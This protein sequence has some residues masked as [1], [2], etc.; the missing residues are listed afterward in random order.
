MFRFSS[1]VVGLLV[2]F[3]VV[4]ASDA[5]FGQSTGSASSTEPSTYGWMGMHL[6]A[7]TPRGAVVRFSPVNHVRP[8]H[9]YR[10][11]LFSAIGGRSWFDTAG[12]GGVAAMYGRTTEWLLGRASVATGL[13]VGGA[14]RAFEEDARVVVGLPVE[15]SIHLTPPEYAV[16]GLEVGAFAHLNTVWPYAG[17]SVGLTVGRLR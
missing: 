10:V 5:A 1:V 15:A 7:T 14:N 2:A 4:G 12:H 17:V 16:V 9:L 13:S 3:S 6:G 11:E 8:P